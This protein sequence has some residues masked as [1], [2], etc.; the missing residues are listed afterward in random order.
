MERALSP[1]CV[2][3][4]VDLGYNWHDVNPK[5]TRSYLKNYRA[6]VDEVLGEPFSTEL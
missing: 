2:L 1:L 3:I 6:F 4:G 5:L